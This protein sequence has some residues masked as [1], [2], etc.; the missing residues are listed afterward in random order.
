M[1]LCYL[2]G[3]QIVSNNLNNNGKAPNNRNTQ[4]PPPAPATRTKPMDIQ[5]PRNKNNNNHSGLY[6][7]HIAS[8]WVHWHAQLIPMLLNM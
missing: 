2:L 4:Q 1:Y 5:A 6:S 3:S 7:L 8:S